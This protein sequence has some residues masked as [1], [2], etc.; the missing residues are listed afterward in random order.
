MQDHPAE[1]DVSAGPAY[2]AQG[3]CICTLSD[4][5]ITNRSTV[6]LT[7]TTPHKSVPFLTRC[8]ATWVIPS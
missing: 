4:S 7:L 6:N 8:A 3:V 5:M 1:H 2:D